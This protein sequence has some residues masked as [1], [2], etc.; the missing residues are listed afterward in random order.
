MKSNS[1]SQASI[2]YLH[3]TLKGKRKAGGESISEAKNNAK[4]KSNN[5][6]RGFG[7]MDKYNTSPDRK[8]KKHKNTKENLV[9][10]GVFHNS[11]ESCILACLLKPFL[12]SSDC[13]L[14]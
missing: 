3:M 11:T 6:S 9:S 14:L 10:R 1:A 12:L 13:E 8:L 5:V 4:V 7:F 2:G